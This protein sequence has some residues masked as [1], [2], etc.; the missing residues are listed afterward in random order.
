MRHNLIGGEGFMLQDA[1][2]RL[3]W[4]FSAS[5]AA[6]RQWVTSAALIAAVGVVYFLS[7]WLSLFLLTKPDGVAVFW[8]AAGVAAGILIALGPAARWPV[9]VGAMAATILAN[10]TG[11][12]TIWSA[13]VFAVCNAG[14]AVLVAGLI[15]YYFDAPFS[16]DRLSHVLGLLAAAIVA[17]AISGIGGTAGYVFFHNSAT[18]VLTIWYHWFTSDALGILTIAPL[19]IGLVSSAREP[20]T[21]NEV[22]HGVVALLALT[23]LSGTII[24]LPRESWA[25]VVPIAALFPL[26]LW[27][28]ARCQPTFAAAAAFIAALTIVWTTTFGIG[29]FGDTHFPIGERILSA[30]AGILAVSLCALVLA[31]LFAERRQHEAVLMESEARLQE[32]LTVGAVTAFDWD[33]RTGL[34]RRSANAAQIFGFDPQHAF[35]AAQFLQRVH[36]DDRARFKA[37]V[38]GVRPESPSYVATFRFIRPD[39]REVWLEETSKAEFDAVRRLARLK[40]L[41]LDVTERKRADER[42]DLLIAELDHRVKNVLA[43]VAVVAMQTRQGSNS[44]AEFVKALDGRIQSMAAAHSLLSQSRWQGVGLDDLVRHQ[45][46]PYATDANTMIR[47]SNI[48]L[49]AVATQVVAT[50]LHE[51]A[52]N[53]AKYGA[54]STP[55][56]HVSVGWDR[57]TDGDAADSLKIVWHEIGGPPIGAPSQPGFGTTLIRDLIPHEL[58]GTVQ[59]DFNRDGAHC[60]IEFPLERP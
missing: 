45:L 16:L 31:A 39:G 13:V 43:R 6:P 48:M 5:A 7:A 53:A 4:Q 18:P 25:T 40:G 22:V 3:E 59:L 28:A 57:A 52:T 33:V 20:P 10:L 38:S 19:L 14:E 11:D 35:T 44:M 34:S 41:T 9:V 51:L 47:G 50:V 15:E 58:G 55:V 12:R 17:T 1:Q 29:I 42:H 26:L 54:L 21:R 23:L 2:K 27:L 60:T 49:T 56:G 36:P 30:Q 32:A 46:A 37:Q 24:F 8:P